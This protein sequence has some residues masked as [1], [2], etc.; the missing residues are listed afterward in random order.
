MPASSKLYVVR[1]GMLLTKEI[2][3]HW[4]AL[5]DKVGISKAEEQTNFFGA[6]YP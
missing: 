3:E 4:Q 6:N 5:A 1:F 2:S